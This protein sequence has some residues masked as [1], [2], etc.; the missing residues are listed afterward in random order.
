MSPVKYKLDL[1][2]PED[3]ILHSHRCENLKSYIDSSCFPVEPTQLRPI[4]T[5]GLTSP[6]LRIR[7]ASGVCPQWNC[8]VSRALWIWT[9]RNCGEWNPVEV[10][11][12]LT[13]TN[14]L[15]PEITA[16]IF[17]PLISSQ[18]I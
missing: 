12:L 13:D 18:F 3:D 1:Y 9:C 11:Q 2:L 5:T 6:R 4:D 8:K 14:M 10:S 7:P 16:S 15:C 17:S